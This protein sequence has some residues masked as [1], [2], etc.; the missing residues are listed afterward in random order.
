MRRSVILML[1][2]ILLTACEPS[3]QRPGVMLS[4]EESPVPENWQFTDEYK[5]IAIQVSTPWLVPHAVTI[6][7]AQVDGQLYV[8]ASAPETKNWPGWVVDDPNVRLK[9]DDRVYNVTLDQLNNPDEIARVQAAYAAKYDLNPEG[10]MGTS[11]YWR[12][13]ARG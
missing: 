1:S 6:W 7:C 13:E 9:I 11:R 2:V 4:G 12:V 5:E 8:A 10:R 3:G